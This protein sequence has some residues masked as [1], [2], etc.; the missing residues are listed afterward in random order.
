MLPLFT[1]TGVLKNLSL[2][3]KDVLEGI[4]KHLLIES[5]QTSVVAKRSEQ[6]INGLKH[7]ISKQKE[8]ELLKEQFSKLLDYYISQRE[9][10]GWRASVVK[11][12]ELV[13]HIRQSLKNL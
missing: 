11:K 9:E 5:E 10:M 13:V 6:V 1:D 7:L 4:G 8:K 12:E 3:Q 2:R